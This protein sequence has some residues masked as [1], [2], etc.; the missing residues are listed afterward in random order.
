MA[1][2]IAILGVGGKMGIWF[3]KYF[4]ANG[5]EVIGYDN[6]EEIKTKGVSKAS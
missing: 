2:N 6:D 3:A 5:Y 1:K 4:L